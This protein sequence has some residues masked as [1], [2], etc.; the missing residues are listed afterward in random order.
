MRTKLKDLRKACGFS[1][2]TFADALRISRS[3]YSQ[4]EAGNKTPSLPIARKIKVILGYS[5]D[6]IFDVDITAPAPK[7]GAPKKFKN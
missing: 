3:H 5:G 2:Y 1:Q 4:I 7:R 6:D